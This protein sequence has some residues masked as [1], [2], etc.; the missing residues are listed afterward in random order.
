VPRGT[1]AEMSEVTRILASIKSDDP[2]AADQLLPLVYDEL[3]KLAAQKL[4][5]E[6]PGQTLQATALVHEA[7]LRLV[8]GEQ[9]QS[10]EGRRH[11][12]AA[13]AEAMRRI[14]VENARHKSTRKAGHGRQRLP[15]D[16]MEATA[17]A[18]PDDLLALDE[19]LTNLGRENQVAA[20]LAKLRL[21]TGLTV[22]EAA[23]ALGISR[24]TGFRLWS[25]GRAFLQAE[26]S[27]D[28]PS[29]GE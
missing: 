7:Y 3:R 24:R 14:L 2:I 25:Y 13:A 19:A 4:A 16:D 9:T 26:L 6:K 12:F 8:A 5:Q 18:S 17:G 11:F 20:D 10:W 28:D 22:D 1:L 21:F 27:A 29:A 15:L 23:D